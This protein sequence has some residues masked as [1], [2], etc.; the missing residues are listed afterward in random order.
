MY[1]KALRTNK[2]T[3]NLAQ[4]PDSGKYQHARAC[5]Q[6]EKTEVIEEATPK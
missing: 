4:R 5:N 2:Y 1:E 3:D 6:A